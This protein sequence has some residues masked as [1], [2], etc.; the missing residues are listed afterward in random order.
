VSR[1]RLQPPLEPKV[2]VEIRRVAFD[3]ARRTRVAA[4]LLRILD[5]P[6]TPEEGRRS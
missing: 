3:P 2:H 6:V 1:D 5:T 4:T